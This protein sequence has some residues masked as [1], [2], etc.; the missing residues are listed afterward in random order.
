VICLL[1]VPPAGQ[2]NDA[3]YHLVQLRKI[4]EDTSSGSGSGGKGSMPLANT[5]L[6]QLQEACTRCTRDLEE[7]WSAVVAAAA[8]AAAAHNSKCMANDIGASSVGRCEV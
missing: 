4:L 8:A 5:E 3:A 2:F 7:V 6:Q 1:C